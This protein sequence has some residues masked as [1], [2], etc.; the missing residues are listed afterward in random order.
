MRV[1]MGAGRG[2]I[3]RQ[4][5]TESLLLAAIG[6]GLGL[7]VAWWGVNSLGNI[8]PPPGRLPIPGLG[9]TGGILAL[10]RAA[11][12]NMRP[13][14]RFSARARCGYCSEIV[15]DI[16]TD[17]VEVRPAFSSPFRLDSRWSSWY[18]RAC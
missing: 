12:G 10:H 14:V 8:Y 1:M 9:E 4:F 17:E 6:G 5:L 7:L 11:V 13:A 2:R 3:V 16:D 15:S 18:R